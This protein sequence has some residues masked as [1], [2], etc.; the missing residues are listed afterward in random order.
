M[1]Y[2][3]ERGSVHIVF[4]LLNHLLNLNE[5]RYGISTVKIVNKFILE[6]IHSLKHILHTN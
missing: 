6:K 2:W 4:Y 5:I 3:E 1:P